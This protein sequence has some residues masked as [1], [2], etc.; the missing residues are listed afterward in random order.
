MKIGILTQP[1]HNNYGGILQN[2][3]LQQ[4]L[5]DM[6]HKVWTIDRK[7]QQITLIRKILS[8]VKRIVIR[9]ILQ[10]NIKIRVWPT[11]KERNIISKHTQRFII[12]NIQT[13]ELIESAKKISLVKKY[14]FDAYIVGSDQVWRPKY[15]PGLSNYFLDFVED[16]KSIKR[17]AYAASFGVENWEFNKHQTKMAKS[18]IKRF[19]GV[20]VREKSAISMCNEFLNNEAV[21]VLDPTLLLS[22]NDYVNILS[23]NSIPK[24]RGNLFAY[25]LDK[26]DFKNRIITY[27]TNELKLKP[28]NL[29]PEKKFTEIQK[30]QIEKTIYSSVESW[31]RAFFDAKFVITDSFHGTVFSIL[32]NKPF[33]S[34]NNK[35]RGATRFQS[36]LKMFD[37]SSRLISSDYDIN[38]KKLSKILFE[39]I[40]F[41]SVNNELE[42]QRTLSKQFLLNNLQKK[43]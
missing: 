38:N 24:S 3:A 43:N 20:S 32:F 41:N 5:M 12:E 35:G 18:L 19:D 16:D 25:I 27:V 8:I 4:V 40:N 29:M 22:K 11:K 34:I 2:F 23:L 42:K 14:N 28:F 9:F 10:R 30:N 6:G 7:N 26:T 31:L 1:L 37:L 39:E 33:I 21:Q 15:S 36:L 13:T 17:I